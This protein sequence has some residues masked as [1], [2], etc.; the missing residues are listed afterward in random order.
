MQANFLEVFTRSVSAVEPSIVVVSSSKNSVS[1]ASVEN[2][3][4][5][6]IPSRLTQIHVSTVETRKRP[7]HTVMETKFSREMLRAWLAEHA[8][9]RA[10]IRQFVQVC[11]ESWCVL[12]GDPHV[13]TDMFWYTPHDVLL[14]IICPLSSRNAKL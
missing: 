2:R 14:T 7:R 10:D 5:I 3:H 11:K 12:V 9:L 4:G 13:L 8:A 1:C 6:R